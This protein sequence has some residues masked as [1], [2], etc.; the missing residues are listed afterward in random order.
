MTLNPASTIFVNAAL[1][2]G[3]RVVD[4]APFIFEMTRK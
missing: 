2:G 3:R 4:R 1:L